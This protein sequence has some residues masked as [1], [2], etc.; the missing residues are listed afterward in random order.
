MFETKPWTKFYGN[1]P[2]TIDYP[3]V[4]LYEALMKTVGRFPDKIAWDFMG[5]T[6]TYKE[7]AEEIDRCANALAAHRT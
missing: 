5:Y 6:G 1:V 7:F 3:R 2:Q 4:T